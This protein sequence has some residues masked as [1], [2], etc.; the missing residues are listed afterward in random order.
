MH[1]RTFTVKPDGTSF[2]TSDVDARDKFGHPLGD[3][4]NAYYRAHAHAARCA[5]KTGVPH[6]VLACDR[7]NEPQGFGFCNIEARILTDIRILALS[8][9]YCFIA[10]AWLPLPAEEE[11]VERQVYLTKK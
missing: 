1:I 5:A 11:E 6:Y 10:V 8:S 2:D 7:G 3:R 9:F 4:A